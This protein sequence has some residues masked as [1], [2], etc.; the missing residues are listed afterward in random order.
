MAGWAARCASSSA[1][2]AR[3]DLAGTRQAI[4]DLRELTGASPGDI[5]R[6]IDARNR[7]GQA[8]ER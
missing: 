6:W 8:V 3:A 7:P 4:A 2:A 1:P 5:R